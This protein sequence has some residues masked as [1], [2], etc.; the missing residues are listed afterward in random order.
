MIP[1][2]VMQVSKQVLE[3]LADH[4]GNMRRNRPNK[5]PRGLVDVRDIA[6]V[7]TPTIFEQ[8]TRCPAGEVFAAR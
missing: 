7:E 2:F 3:S 1:I 5:L 4:I 6:A 8:E